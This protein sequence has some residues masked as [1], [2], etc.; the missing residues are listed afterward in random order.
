MFVII[1]AFPRLEDVQGRTDGAVKA[2]H[3]AYGEL[4]QVRLEFA[5]GQFD[6]VKGTIEADL[7]LGRAPFRRTMIAQDTGSAIVGPARADIYF[8]AGDQAGQVA[9]R[10]RQAAAE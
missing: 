9:S 8:G 3:G 10:V 4:A 6:R 2:S 5:V 1:G 7:P